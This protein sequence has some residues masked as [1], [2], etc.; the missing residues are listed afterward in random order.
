V[1]GLKTET[2]LV[3][4]MVFLTEAS[5][6]SLLAVLAKGLSLRRAPRFLSGFFLS[7]RLLSS[8]LGALTCKDQER[9]ISEGEDSPASPEVHKLSTIWCS[10]AVKEQRTHGRHLVEIL[11]SFLH[12][13][14]EPPN[15]RPSRI[16]PESQLLQRRGRQFA[17]DALDLVT[18][19]DAGEVGVGHDGAG[20][21]VS[22]LGGGG[23][24]VGAVDG[25]QLV[26]GTLCPDDKPSKVTSGGQL[27]KVQPRNPSRSRR[28]QYRYPDSCCY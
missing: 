25:V 10:T 21:L 20:Q 16:A 7:G 12:L 27:K 28:I 22:L 18:V 2:R 23:L 15:H 26:K 14:Y 5:S 6:S 19:D 24:V 11:S 1:L 17:Y 13:Y 9:M 8:F 3:L 4:L